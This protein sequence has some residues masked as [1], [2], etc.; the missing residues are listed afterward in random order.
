MIWSL[1]SYSQKKKSYSLDLKV[2]KPERHVLV[3]RRKP[4]PHTAKLGGRCSA[5]ARWELLK[6]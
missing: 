3:T 5:E 1:D 2:L 4:R 6:G